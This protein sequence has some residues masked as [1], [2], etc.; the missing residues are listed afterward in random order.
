VLHFYSG[1]PLQ[2]LSGVDSVSREHLAL[3][4]GPIFLAALKAIGARIYAAA[5]W[6]FL[7]SR[8]WTNVFHFFIAAR[9]SGM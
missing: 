1:Q 6:R 7:L 5:I 4:V 3:T 9:F 2:N 8:A